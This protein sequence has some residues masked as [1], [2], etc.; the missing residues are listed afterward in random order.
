MKKLMS[1]I[2]TSLIATSLLSGCGQTNAATNTTTTK[3][4]KKYTI[5]T[6]ATYAPFEFQKDG[7]YTG[8][9]IDL[10]NAI[11]K[12]EG[13]NYELTAM[14]FKGIIPALQA[15]QIDGAIAGMSI[16]EERKNVLDF[17]DG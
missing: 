6:D 3:S 2:A 10:L 15:N 8:I 1:L 11:S 9:D 7:N 16:T 14:D 13:F 17:S 4:V 5:A 12:L